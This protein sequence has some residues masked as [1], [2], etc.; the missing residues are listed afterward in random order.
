MPVAVNCCVVPSTIEG[1]AGV[2]AIDVR[3]AWTLREVE[4]AMAVPGS[5]AV[6]VVVPTATLVARPSVPA[7]LLTVATDGLVELH[8]TDAVRSWLEPSLNVPVAVNGCVVP[9]PIEGS[10][11][12]T[13]MEVSTGGVTVSVVDPATAVPGSVALTV[14]V[15]SETLVASPS[16]PAALLRVATAG[17]V[18]LQVTE[19]VR[20]CV[21]LSL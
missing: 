11:G 1:S 15:P 2:T 14:V 7:A 17:L 10:A 3:T 19:A 13:S 5:V 21:E 20:S 16:V 18:E 8:V 6:T 9:S 12:V 4:P